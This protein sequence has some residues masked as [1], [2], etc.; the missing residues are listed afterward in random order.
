MLG[1]VRLMF[2]VLNCLVVL[3]FLC[4]IPWLRWAVPLG[5][6]GK[7]ADLDRAGVIDE[8]KLQEAYP[9]LA[10][11]TRHALPMWLTEDMHEAAT[12]TAAAGAVA[13]M[14]NLALLIFAHQS[15]RGRDA[16]AQTQGRSPP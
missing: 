8:T 7:V 11:N 16:V 4:A 10:E 1:K 15:R 5:T 12:R 3:G 13:A 9:E 14:L 2:V 6:V